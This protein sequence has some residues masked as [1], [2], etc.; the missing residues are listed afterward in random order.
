MPTA[1]VRSLLVVPRV[2]G[3]TVLLLLASQNFARPPGRVTLK[4]FLS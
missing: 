2:E 4:C 3:T 1:T